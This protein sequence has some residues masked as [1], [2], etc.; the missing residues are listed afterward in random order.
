[1]ISKLL[2]RRR[3]SSRRPDSTVPPGERIYAI[4]D[5]HGRLD[6]LDDLLAQIESDD[7]RRGPA[8]TTIVFLGDLVDRGPDSAGVIARL[9]H[10]SANRPQGATRFLLGNHE[11]VFLRAVSGDLP[12][13]KFFIRIGG[14]ET[15]ISFGMSEA[16]YLSCD[17][18][19]LMRTFRAS[20]SA[21]VIEFVKS[22]EDSIVIGDY[23]FVHAGLRPQISLSEQKSHDLRWIRDEF[24]TFKGA[25]EKVVIHGHSVSED[26]DLQANR[27]G[28]DTGAFASGRLSAVGLEG[29]ERWFLQ[30]AALQHHRT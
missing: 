14:R 3:G 30:T 7:A 26:I 4:G 17:F 6:L 22:F 16:E 15:I 27:I 11:E 9:Q 10:L 19:S 12:A 21:E 5:I 8:Q 29:S 20:V 24:L 1:M 25:F 28:V 23:V 13:L 2:S 18:D